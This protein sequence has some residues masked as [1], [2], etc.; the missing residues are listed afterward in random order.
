MIDRTEM[1]PLLPLIE[2]FEQQGKITK[3]ANSKQAYMLP[4]LRDLILFSA[5]NC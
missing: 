5:L 2:N 3:Q 1:E 4:R